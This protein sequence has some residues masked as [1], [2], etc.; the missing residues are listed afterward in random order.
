MLL[1]VVACDAAEPTD[2]RGGYTLR[3]M[4]LPGPDDIAPPRLLETSDRAL[5]A[6]RLTYPDWLWRWVQ[7]SG[8]LAL[9]VYSGPISWW[10]YSPSS[11]MS[12]MRSGLIR[13]LYWLLLVRAVI[14]EHGI[15]SVIWR[16]EDR[17]LARVV[18]TLARELGASFEC[19][20]RPPPMRA[21][22]WIRIAGR[23]RFGVV[24]TAK[25]LLLRMAGFGRFPLRG[26]ET[27]LYSRFPVLWEER[28]GVLQERLYGDWPSYLASKGQDVAFIALFTGPLLDLLVRTRSLHKQCRDSRVVFVEALASL[29]DLA[30]AHFNLA[31][32]F[33]Y[34]LWR[35]RE[36]RRAVVFEG[37]DVSTLLRREIDATAVSGEVPN[38]R[39]LFKAA[40]RALDRLAP[41]KTVCVPFEFQPME[42]AVTLAARQR[43]IRVV[44]VQAAIWT[45]N[46]MGL[47]FLASQARV[48]LMDETRAPLP[49][50]MAAFGSLPHRVLAERLGADRVCLSGPIRYSHLARPA[51]TTKEAFLRGA[52]L[53]ADSVVVLVALS[54]SRAESL[55][56]L[57]ASF[58]AAAVRTNVILALRFHYF[59]PMHAESRQIAARF[60]SVRSHVCDGPFDDL[61]AV[62]SV[63]VCGGS[64]AGI[65]AIARG[66]VPLVFRP[67]GDVPANATLEVPE[68][69]FFWQTADDLGRVLN[70]ALSKDQDYQV[71]Q[72]RWPSALHRQLWPIDGDI[73]ARLYDFLLA[74]RFE[75]K[76][77]P[78]A[79]VDRGR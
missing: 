48:D 64:S 33:R 8:I 7:T 25:C 56:M 9:A 14:R 62:A 70:S 40:G 3:L 51:A 15:T 67:I 42:R 10:W 37:I 13:H 78:E 35:R 16:G 11:E 49:D 65:E 63:L 19:I 38:N 54:P 75:S 77:E 71:R 47:S 20:L 21:R 44:G 66:C 29:R 76:S 34:M 61:L 69:A 52:G 74:K 12:P 60:S 32:A 55:A 41:V 4:G 68:A 58:A 18:G 31:F 50:V 26:A 36:R 72:E 45:S 17:A 2:R 53:P 23:L 79:T 73:S 6:L 39:V 46:Q 27:V 28:R 59:L 43:G 22:L 24:H 57:E 5:E 30:Q 1:T